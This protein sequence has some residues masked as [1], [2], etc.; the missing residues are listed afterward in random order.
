MALRIP[1][2]WLQDFVDLDQSPKK[3]AE[4]LTISGME[5]ESIEYLG[6]NWGDFCRV[7]EVQKV[8]AHP[9]ADSLSIATVDYGTD[10]SLEV[11]T[12]APNIRELENSPRGTPPKVALALSGATLVDPYHDHHPL[13]RLKPSKIRGILSEGMICSEL[14]LGL[15]EAHEGV[16]FLPEDA[17]VGRMLKDYLGDAILEFD[18]KGGFAHL[19]SIFGLA[20]ETATIT[21]MPLKSEK[22]PDL[23]RLIFQQPNQKLKTSEADFVKPPLRRFSRRN[24]LY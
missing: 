15:G 1:L 21:R 6:S 11:V 8:V 16:L 13:I 20:R 5:V 19:L 23:S 17:P 24:T 3:L 10:Q 14:E 4:A 22:L 18:I 7:G 12:G 9:N 2:S